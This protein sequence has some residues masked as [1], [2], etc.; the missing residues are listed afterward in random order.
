MNYIAYTVGPIYDTL[1]SAKKQTRELWAGSYFFSL[2]MRKLLGHI[3]DEFEILL[4]YVDEQCLNSTG[5]MGI[6]HDRFVARSQKSKDEIRKIL[7]NKVGLVFAELAAI[8][9]DE[10]IQY[11]LAGN[12]N[13]HSLIASEEDLKSVNE[14]VIFAINTILDGMEQKRTFCFESEH[15]H[16]ADFQTNIHS[17]KQ[18]LGLSDKLVFTS[19]Q[20]I[21]GEQKYY[22]VVTADGD[23][24]RNYVTKLTGNGDFSN[25]KTLSKNL[26]DFFTTDK[27]LYTLTNIDFGGMLIYAGGDDVLAFVPIKLGSHTFLDYITALDEK[28]KT[29]V[30]NDT[31]LSFGVNIIYHKY[32]M[33]KAIAQAFD[34]LHTSKEHGQNSLTLQVTKHSGQTFSTTIKMGEDK[35][36]QF[37]SIVDGV[38]RETIALPHSLHHS[39]K[40]YESA[41]VATYQNGSSSDEM[42]KN[43]F[44]DAKGEKESAGLKRMQHYLDICK[45]STQQAFDAFFS[46]LS[47]IKFL[48]GD[49][50]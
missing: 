31:S 38:F 50:A 42:F 16:I 3:K 27:S 11:E 40:R 5:Y 6:F 29:V 12:M 7:D 24:M 48:R 43:V 22:A 14:N 45:P 37:S 10:S 28:F 2:F 23:K 49:R 25:I 9:K 44:N 36:A 30:A 39:L 47:I 41:I 1:Y 26:Y 32:P 46:E 15:N 34:L 18:K 20:E 35:F 8:I 33:R 4:P 13:N 19:T 17:L 21:A